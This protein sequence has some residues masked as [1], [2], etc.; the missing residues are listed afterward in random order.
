MAQ[1]D[2]LGVERIATRSQAHDADVAWDQ[3]HQHEYQRGGSQQGRDHQQHAL[4]DVAI[5]YLSSQI[6]ARSWFR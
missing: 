5:H 1:C 6:V 3:P 4:D 2:G